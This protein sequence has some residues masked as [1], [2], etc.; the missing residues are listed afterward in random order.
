MDSLTQI[1]LGAAVGELAQGKKLGN[2][3]MIWGAIAGTIPDLDVF[4]GKLYKDPV[5]ELAFHRGI[6]HSFFFALTFSMV[7]SY[8]T[9]WLYDK[10]TYKKLGFAYTFVSVLL[11]CI[12]AI[13]YVAPS[14]A[15]ASAGVGAVLVPLAWYVIY[16]YRKYLK[17]DLFDDINLGVKGWYVLFFWAIFT[18]PILD[19]FTVY[20][21]QVF[22]P[23]SDYRVSFNN[24]SVAD[25]AYTVPFLLCVVIAAVCSRFSR[26]R[27]YF[28]IL[29]IV[30]SSLYMCWTF[31][32]KNRV[33][34]VVEATLAD[35]GITYQRYMTSPTI[36]N[37]IL[38]T[39]TVETDSLYLQ[40]QYS[41][42]DSDKKVDLVPIPKNHDWLGANSADHTI[43]R[44]RW[45]SNDYYGIMK[46]TDGRLQLN[47]LRYGSFSGHAL[48]ENDFIFRF[49][50]DRGPDGRYSMVDSEAG[51][52]DDVGT[53]MVTSL[54]SRIQG[55][56]PAPVYK[57]GAV[58][59]AH[60]LATD[61]GLQILKDGGNAYDAA[62]AVH[63]ALAV[64]YPRAGN[65][66]GGGF[67]TVHTADG[68]STT[69]DFREKAPTKAS[70]N[71]YLDEAGN[72]IPNRSTAGPLASG[73][74]GSVKGMKLLYDSLCTMPLAR[75]LQ[76]AVNLAQNGF[77]ISSNEANRLNKYRPQLTRHNQ[78][79]TPYTAKN[80]W[81]AGDTLK[82]VDLGSTLQR[83][84]S[85]GLD[86]F[87]TGTTAQLITQH[88]QAIGGLIS[89]DD[90]NDYSAIWRKPITC[91]YGGYKVIS[92]PPPSSGGI[93]LCQLLHGVSLTRADTLPHNSAD[94]IHTLAELEK[95]V[96]AIRNSLLG[97]P[98][99]VDIDQSQLLSEVFLDELYSSI[100][101]EATTSVMDSIEESALLRESFETTHFSII[102]KHGNAI[103]IT[104]TLNGNYG[105]Y[106]VARGTGIL[107]NNEMDDFTARPGTPNQYGLLGSERNAIAPGKR[108]LSSM[109]P[110]IVLRDG[111]P[112]MILGSPGGPTI[113]TAVLQTLLNVS[114]HNMTLQEAVDAP[115]FHDQGYPQGILVEK[116][117]LDQVVLDSLRR[118]GH[119]I[120]TTAYMGAVEAILIDEQRNIRAAADATRGQDDKAEGY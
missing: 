86:E 29:G 48:D 46:R 14:L 19:C 41:F 2:R 24:I 71:M 62:V 43:N 98:D 76:P 57:N 103:S 60:G 40:G 1:V 21:T 17:G 72:T 83:L 53:D 50:L 13:I 105:S 102:D 10:G 35:Q 32:N 90:L 65:L 116:G 120:R 97:D 31:Y 49:V 78:G 109:S 25:P 12:A 92:M 107:L 115:R 100:G 91:T 38:W 42:Y 110:T 37:N 118:K 59:T 51:P 77:A 7:L 11:I 16:R 58:A 111:R 47:D 45:F 22:L 9:Y 88:Q 89:L 33:N 39:T 80:H 55:N 66:G 44:L 93:A 18:H 119:S 69:L 117:K 8:F 104:T 68:T 75:L 52:P 4:V 28:N 67:A 96:F 15:V 73:V 26:F 54:M 84:A 70:R 95:R 101:Q 64:V 113:I 20:G 23:F 56:K 27:R 5:D 108:M 81:Q 114:E 34:R 63:F 94:Y 30:L 36:L 79:T 99:F 85:R 74:P 6:S 61:I 106:V 112:A 3:A 87:Y 82:N